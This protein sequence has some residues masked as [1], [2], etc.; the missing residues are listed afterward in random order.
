MDDGLEQKKWQYLFFFSEQKTDK[1]K[2][3][4]RV[5]CRAV[6]SCYGFAVVIFCVVIFLRDSSFQ[7]WPK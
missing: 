6:Y 2:E 3:D 4:K 7:N 1:K 5:Q